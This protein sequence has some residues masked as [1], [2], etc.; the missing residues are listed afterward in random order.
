MADRVG[1]V[2]EAAAV[3]EH[4]VGSEDGAGRAEGGRVVAVEPQRG[5]LDVGAVEGRV[6]DDGGRVDVDGRPGGVGV[7]AV[8]VVEACHEVDGVDDYELE[9]RGSVGQVG[10]GTGAAAADGVA[11]RFVQHN[12]HVAERV[13]EEGRVDGAAFVEW[14]GEWLGLGLVGAHDVWRNCCTDAV[15]VGAIVVE[16]GEV[17][18]E[19]SIGLLSASVGLVKCL[20]Y[21]Q[22]HSLDNVWS[23]NCC[24]SCLF[25]PSWQRR[26]SIVAFMKSPT[27]YIC[28][29]CYRNVKRDIVHWSCCEGVVGVV[30]LD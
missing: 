23:P 30:D 9:C 29:A 16:H 8:V 25:G 26:H 24:I 7:V 22:A 17:H 21:Q 2:G 27:R 5:G 13:G 11:V 4:V 14:A 6:G 19:R 3:E 28:S 18:H 20:V 15:H 12:R 10:V 1:G